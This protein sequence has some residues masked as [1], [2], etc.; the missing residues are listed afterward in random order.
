M[1]P[2]R[3]TPPC[4]FIAKAADCGRQE[5]AHLWD[6][7]FGGGGKP[8]A[9]SAPKLTVHNYVTVEIDGKAVTKAVIKGRK[10]K[11]SLS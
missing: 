7:L 9:S 4:P 11:A 10:H 6:D 3:T 1:T 8:S 2:P 5:A